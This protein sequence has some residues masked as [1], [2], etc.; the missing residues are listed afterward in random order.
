MPTDWNALVKA[1]FV[2]DRT[3]AAAVR[4]KAPPPHPEP[5]ATLKRIPVMF[6]GDPLCP[7]WPELAAWARAAPA[8]AFQI[9]PHRE[10]HYVDREL[11]RLAILDTID[12]ALGA[13]VVELIYELR[14][15]KERWEAK[16]C[17]S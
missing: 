17:V 6:P 4:R 2:K 16:R 13:V 10:R 7:E 9:L 14:T 8:G 5:P 3:P 11:L 12:G 1:A 15:M